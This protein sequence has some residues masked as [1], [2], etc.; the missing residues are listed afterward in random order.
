MK[1]ARLVYR[2]DVYDGKVW[3]PAANVAYIIADEKGISSNRIQRT[4]RDGKIASR[5]VQMDIQ[6]S[7]LAKQM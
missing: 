4:Q 7:I 6:S 1:G 3:N 2:V 5:R